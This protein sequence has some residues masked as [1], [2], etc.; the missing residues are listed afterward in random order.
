MHKEIKSFIP[1]GLGFIV[2]CIMME[3]ILPNRWLISALYT[4][5]ILTWVFALIFFRN[6][7][8]TI[9]QRE[10]DLIFA[11]ADGKLVVYEK[12]TV[13]EHLEEEMIQLS[14][15]MSP[16]NVHVNRTPV[17]G[18]VEYYKYHPGQFLPAWNPKASTD[19]ERSTLVIKSDFGPKILLR[20]IAGAMARRVVTY[21]KDND[22]VVQGEDFGF[23]RIGSRVDVFLPTDS[24]ILVSLNQKIIGNRTVL[25]RL[26]K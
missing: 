22:Q 5:C 2:I 1:F 8:R 17:S 9:F 26:K 15:F 12:T 4:L 10:D 11:P 23:I 14:I 3:M 25:A 21:V 18:I 7:P 6:P 16:L 20:Q 19:N 13:T 24:E